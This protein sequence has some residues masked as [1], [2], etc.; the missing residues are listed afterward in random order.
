MSV[1]QCTQCK[2]N[3]VIDENANVLQVIGLDKDYIQDRKKTLE[4]K[5]YL[6]I[7]GRAAAAFDIHYFFCY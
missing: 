6:Q 4:Q 7:K 2:Q 5:P 1:L 3:V